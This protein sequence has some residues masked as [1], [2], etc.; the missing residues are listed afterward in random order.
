MC[1][2]ISGETGC[3]MF[4]MYCMQCCMS[5]QL[6][7]SAWMCCL[8]EVYTCLNCDM[9]GVVN[10]FLD[11]LKLCVVCINNRMYICCGEFNVV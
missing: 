2:H 1:I 3:C 8:E 10:V 5:C 6:F 11:H 4:V 9:F 7:C